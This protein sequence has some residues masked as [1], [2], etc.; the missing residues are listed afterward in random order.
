MCPLFLGNVLSLR[1]FAARLPNKVSLTALSLLAKAQI[2]IKLADFQGAKILLR[3][4]YNKNTPDDA[5]QENIKNSLKVGRFHFKSICTIKKL[6]NTF[7][8]CRYV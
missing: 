7:F 6:I 3:K 4:A 5:D 1:L 8:S 2:L